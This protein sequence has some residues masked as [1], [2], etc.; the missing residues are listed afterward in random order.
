MDLE[1]TKRSLA[2]DLTRVIEKNGLGRH[3]MQQARSEAAVS[4]VM[5]QSRYSI[6]STEVR[7]QVFCETFEAL[8]KS[9]APQD[10]VG[11]KP[12]AA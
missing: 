1:S 5:I 3:R 9:K 4:R 2:A 10:S 12:V 6:L 7:E 8:T 11:R